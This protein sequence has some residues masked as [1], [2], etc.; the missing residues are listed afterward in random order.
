LAKTERGKHK[1]CPGKKTLLYPLPPEQNGA[2]PKIFP[3]RGKSQEPI[4]WEVFPQGGRTTGSLGAPGR[5]PGLPSPFRA[6]VVLE[7][8]LGQNRFP[9]LPTVGNW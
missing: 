7:V 9:H 3:K 6:P 4:P 2:S 8:F 5:M 1:A